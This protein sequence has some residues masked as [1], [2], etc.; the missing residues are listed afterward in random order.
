MEFVIIATVVLVLAMC[1]G[2]DFV[3][4]PIMLIVFLVVLLLVI[5]GLFVYSAVTVFYTLLTLPT[6]RE[7]C[8]SGVA[9]SLKKKLENR[10]Q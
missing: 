6:N 10:S 5:F 1:L 9:E 2:A 8:F 4:V 7:V 3:I